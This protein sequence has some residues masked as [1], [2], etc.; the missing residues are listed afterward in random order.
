LDYSRNKS[1]Q[2]EASAVMVVEK[3]DDSICF[4]IKL[5]KKYRSTYKIISVAQ[6]RANDHIILKSSNQTKVSWKIIN[7][8]PEK[9]YMTNQNISLEIGSMS[10]TNPQHLSYQFNA[11]FVDSVDRMLNLNNDDSRCVSL[12]TYLEILIRCLWSLLLRRR[13]YRLL[14]N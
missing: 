3:K 10:V 12:L 11:Y 7:K 13:Y 2:T 14:I 4:H 9:R 5:Y 1:L 6:K 8:E